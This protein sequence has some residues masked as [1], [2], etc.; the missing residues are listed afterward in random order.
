MA[1]GPIKEAI[2]RLRH[3]VARE[4][5]EVKDWDCKS[6]REH[7]ETLLEEVEAELER[8]EGLI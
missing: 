7:Y 6:Q 8:I 3:Q 2:N 1:Y 5:R 4:I